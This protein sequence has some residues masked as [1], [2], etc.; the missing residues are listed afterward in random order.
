MGFLVWIMVIILFL[1][2]I[3]QGVNTFFAGVKSGIDKL[4]IT[5]IIETSTNDA[6]KI[7]ENTSRNIIGS[8][9]PMTK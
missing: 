7:T 2:I 8:S 6:L 3:G 1:A 5:P 9:F 4:G